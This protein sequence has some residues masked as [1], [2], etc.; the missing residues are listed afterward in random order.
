MKAINVQNLKRLKKALQKKKLQ[1]ID[2]YRMQVCSCDI[3]L[4]SRP[5][6]DGGEAP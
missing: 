5:Q 2:T 1:R 3:Y 4:Q 6:N